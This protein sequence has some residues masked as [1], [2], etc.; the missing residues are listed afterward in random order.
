MSQEFQCPPRILTGEG[1]AAQLGAVAQ[2]LGL[3]KVLVVTDKVLNEKT[4]S[5]AAAVACLRASS[6]QV[7]IF[8]EVEPDPLVTTAQRSIDCARRV[9][10]NG[11]V[12]L[13]GGMRNGCGQS[14]GGR[15]RECG[16]IAR[17]VGNREHAEA[18]PSHRP[19]AR[20]GRNRK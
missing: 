7:D 8:D 3:S 12:G 11:I 13:G 5:V 18:R 6:L 15:P 19:V 4:D 2:G 17:H 1:S 20:H 16:T 9:N 10:P 14:H